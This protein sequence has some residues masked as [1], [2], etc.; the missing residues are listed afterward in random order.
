MKVIRLRS[1]FIKFQQLAT[2]VPWDEAALRRQAYNGLAKRIKDDMVHHEKPNTLSGLRKL[3]KA[4]DA[5]YWERRGEVS[6]ELMLLEP[7]ETR[8]NRSLTLPSLTTS[9]A[10]FFTFQAEEHNSAPTQGKGSTSEQKKPTTPNLSFKTRK[11]QKANSPG[12][13]ALS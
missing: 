12:K 4:I 10:K 13:T 5:R 7:P 3:V 2:C 6:R 9:P 11:R 8:P 1:I